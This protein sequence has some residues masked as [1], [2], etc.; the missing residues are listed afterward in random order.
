VALVSLEL[1]PAWLYSKSTY[2]FTNNCNHLSVVLFEWLSNK[3][4]Q[5][6][7]NCTAVGRW[8]GSR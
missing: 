8:R 3:L 5:L 7:N 4:F 6:C 1:L 2:I